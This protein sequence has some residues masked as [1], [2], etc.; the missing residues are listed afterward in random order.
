MSTQAIAQMP[1]RPPPLGAAAP[2]PGD[3]L[4]IPFP[5]DSACL[6]ALR[7]RPNDAPRR[8]KSFL[9]KTLTC[10]NP[11][12]FLPAAAALIHSFVSAAGCPSGGLR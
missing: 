11:P 4:L 6:A 9:E 8:L 7:I 1:H 10:A 5:A 3:A 2:S 12:R